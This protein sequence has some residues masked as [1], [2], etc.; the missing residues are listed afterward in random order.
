MHHW[1][2]PLTV[3]R[4]TNGNLPACHHWLPYHTPPLLRGPRSAPYLGVCRVSGRYLP[5][6]KLANQSKKMLQQWTATR[7]CCTRDCC[8][9]LSS[10]LH[11]V[12]ATP[13]RTADKKLL[14]RWTATR[15]C[16]AVKKTATGL[17]AVFLV[18]WFDQVKGL[19]PPKVV[20]GSARS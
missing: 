2:E 10:L 11:I 13:F 7:D 17:T 9:N 15:F 16:T 8:V 4:T 19:K 20:N 18:T 6:D 14:Q 12:T 5:F 3:R 1:W